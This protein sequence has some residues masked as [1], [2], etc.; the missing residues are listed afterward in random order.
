LYN[1]PDLLVF[2]DGT[3]AGEVLLE[4]LADTLHV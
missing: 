3:V 2:L 4:R 1:L